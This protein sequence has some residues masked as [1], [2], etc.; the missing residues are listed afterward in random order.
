MNNQRKRFC[1]EYVKNGNNGTQ[2]YM[3][4]YPKSNEE[5]ARRMASKL[6]TIIDVQEYIKELQGKTEKKAIMSIEE[7][8]NWL[9][10]IINSKECVSNRLKALEILNKMDGVYTQKLELQGNVRLNNPLRELTT[11]QLVEMINNEK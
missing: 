5:S 7:R 4:A 1:Q 6:L 8:M 3:T 9:T 11:E 2:A 10:G